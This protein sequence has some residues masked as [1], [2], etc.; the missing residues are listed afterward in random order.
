METFDPRILIGGIAIFTLIIVWVIGIALALTRWRRHPRVSLFALIAFV[1]MIVNR[2]L[3]LALPP[4]IRHYSWT[5]DYV[6]SIYL[7]VDISNILVNT[8]VWALVI[9]AIF[10]WRNQRQ[11]ESLFPPAPPTFDHN[12]REQNAT[13]GIP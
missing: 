9:C 5:E 12:P 8:A 13:P 4:M 2:F 7:V 10:G 3:Y 1:L 11:K 6:E